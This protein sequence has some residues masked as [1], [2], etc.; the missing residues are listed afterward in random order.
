MRTHCERRES[1]AAA[2]RRREQ[3]RCFLCERQ[4]RRRILDVRAADLEE[5]MVEQRFFVPPDPTKAA[6]T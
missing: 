3:R 1:R 6:A 2:R 4:R 5:E